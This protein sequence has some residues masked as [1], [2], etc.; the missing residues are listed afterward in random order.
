MYVKF[1]FCFIRQLSAINLESA[2]LIMLGLHKTV[3]F[4]T[5]YN[6]I[7]RRKSICFILKKSVVDVLDLFV[8]LT[9]VLSANSAIFQSCKVI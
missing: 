8:S 9:I 1:E 6:K 3:D 5:V 2:T 4:A 7:F